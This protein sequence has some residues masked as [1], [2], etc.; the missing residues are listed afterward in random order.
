LQREGVNPTIGPDATG[1]MGVRLA[2]VDDSGKHDLASCVIQDWNLRLRDES[3]K[4]VAEFARSVA[5]KR[6]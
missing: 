6:Q 1:G 2:L 4:G 5:S 3:V